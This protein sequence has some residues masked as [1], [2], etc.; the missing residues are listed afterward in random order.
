[1]KLSDV[2]KLIGDEPFGRPVAKKEEPTPSKG[3]DYTFALPDFDERGF[4]TR[5]ISSARVTF[6][7][8]GVAAVAG[9]VARVLQVAS[10]AAGW[11]WQVGFI[12]ILASIWAVPRV[13][14]R[15]GADVDPKDWKAMLGNGFMVFFTGLA[16]WMLLLNVP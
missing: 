10:D 7:A 2:G 16:V 14:K 9:L 4:M 1:M 6:V 8:V 13:A 15:F 11:P 5:E 12:P 3:D